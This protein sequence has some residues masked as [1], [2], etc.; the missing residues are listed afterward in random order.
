[1]KVK[2]ISRKN[3]EFIHNHTYAHEMYGVNKT[4]LTLRDLEYKFIPLDMEGF[5]QWHHCV[6]INGKSTWYCESV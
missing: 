1:M 2:L 5:G 3:G 6:A 4:I